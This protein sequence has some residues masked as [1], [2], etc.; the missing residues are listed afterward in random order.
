MPREITILS[1]TPHDLYA[2][3]E[4][5][6]GIAGTGEVR[7]IEGGTAVQVLTAAGSDLLT[8]YAP[9]ILRTGGEVARLLP[10]APAVE[11]PVYWS[12]AFAPWGDAGEAGVSIALRLALAVDATC[13][14]ED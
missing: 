1:Q 10:D 9:R 2:L 4:A 12:D 3:A 5:A 7:E 14:V 11:L 8:V 13:V 6:E